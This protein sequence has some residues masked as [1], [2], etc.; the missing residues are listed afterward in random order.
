[1]VN[2]YVVGGLF[3]RRLSI[4]YVL[5]E[6]YSLVNR[7]K[8]AWV[9]LEGSGKLGRWGPGRSSNGELCCTE[10]QDELGQGQIFL[11]RGVWVLCNVSS[12]SLRWAKMKCNRKGNAQVV[13]CPIS[14]LQNEVTG[15][16]LS[17]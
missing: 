5:N 7:S 3:P 16:G 15:L 17:S 8:P 10:L 9:G 11:V 1:M 6:D 4:Q 12:S 14:A 2:G 13:R